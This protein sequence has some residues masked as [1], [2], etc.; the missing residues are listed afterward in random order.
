MDPH[1]DQKFSL[2]GQAWLIPL[3]MKQKQDLN[4]SRTTVV[5]KA[6]RCRI[7]AGIFLDKR[8]FF[9]EISSNVAYVNLCQKLLFLHQL[10]H[11]M[12]TDCSLN[13]KFNT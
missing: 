13:Y 5:S 1:P 4:K 2:R 11:D 8:N 9:K 3:K 12:T 6:K 7:I 10:T